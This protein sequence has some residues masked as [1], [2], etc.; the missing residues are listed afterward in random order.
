L[1][2]F[3]PKQKLVE[4]SSKL[5]RLTFSFL[6]QDSITKALLFVIALSTSIIAVELI[7][8]NMVNKG[9]LLCAKYNS[10]TAYELS[11]KAKSKLNLLVG[12]KNSVSKYCN[13]L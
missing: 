6:M 8:V 11:S 9:K 4:S 5:D 3:N 13:S 2:N 10:E 12:Q 1:T 7:P